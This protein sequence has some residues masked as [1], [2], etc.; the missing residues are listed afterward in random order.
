MIG[1]IPTWTNLLA[2][3]VDKTSFI[4]EAK[5][6]DIGDT[7]EIKLFGRQALFA[8]TSPDSS[9]SFQTTF[10]YI[11]EIEQAGDHTIEIITR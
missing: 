7:V 4:F 5:G 2:T 10:S 3:A 1:Y 8:K 11:R 9:T 6:Q